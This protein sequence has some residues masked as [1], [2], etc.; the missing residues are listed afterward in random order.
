MDAYSGSESASDADAE[1]EDSRS[2]VLERRAA[3]LADDVLSDVP[4]RNI[5]RDSGNRTPTRPQPSLRLGSSSPA[6][7]SSRARTTFLR[8]RYHPTRLHSPAPTKSP[9]GSSR[10]QSH[11]DHNLAAAEEPEASRNNANHHM[12]DQGQRFTSHYARHTM[13]F[14]EDVAMNHRSSPTPDSHAGE[15]PNRSETNTERPSDRF[16]PN[17]PPPTGS[18]QDRMLA[19]IL[20][21][22]ERNGRTLRNIADLLKSQDTRRR[23][24]EQDND[25]PDNRDQN[26]RTFKRRPARRDRDTLDLQKTVRSFLQRLESRGDEQSIFPDQP[27][28]DEVKDFLK[29]RN[30]GPTLERFR[31]HYDGMPAGLWNVTAREVFTRVFLETYEEEEPGWTLQAVSDAFYSRIRS[32]RALWRK[33]KEELSPEEKAIKRELELKATR[34]RTR[35]I[36]LWNQRLAEVHAH[37]GLAEAEEV[38]VRLGALGMS[39]DESEDEHQHRIHNSTRRP[40][41]IVRQRTERATWVTRLVRLLDD[42]HYERRYPPGPDRTRGG[43]PRERKIN[44]VIMSRLR[45]M[46][47]QPRNYY[48]PF[49]LGSLDAYRRAELAMRPERPCR[50]SPQYTA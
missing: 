13:G 36:N 42:L 46:L 9:S 35:R 40:T 3:A 11:T 45:P 18:Y 1:P 8:D 20:S 50:L 27:T 16:S 47:G 48:S 44:P 15:Q 31:V 6:P 24:P 10:H 32:R 12:D 25:G 4:I 2:R 22:E 28:T 30:R 33:N 38:L 37:P 23:S 41:Y 17:S 5:D 21:S 34:R 14:D 49:F 19:K 7:S 39:E 43:P 26:W 29:G